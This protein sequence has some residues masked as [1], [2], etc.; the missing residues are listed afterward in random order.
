MY[1]SGVAKHLAILSPQTVKQFFSGKK[2]IET[3]FSKKRIAPFG[4]VSVGDLVYIKPP[5]EEIV[6]QFTA[7]KVIYFEGLDESDWLLIKKQFG[8]K[9]SLGSEEED[10]IYL[11][12]NKDAKFGTI[13]LMDNI[14]KFLT[15]PLK[16]EKKDLRGWVVL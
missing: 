2:T 11:N 13:I 14:E 10:Q 7:K 9:M 5:G 3:R 6:G 1:I 15:N 4:Q 12:K 16:I 8:K